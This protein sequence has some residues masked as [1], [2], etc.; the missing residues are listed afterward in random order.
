MK[1]LLSGQTR[2][3]RLSIAPLAVLLLA[4]LCTSAWAGF[5]ETLPKGAFML[6]E[7]FVHS[8]LDKTWDNDGNA[9]PLIEDIKRYEPGGG[10][11]GVLIPKPNAKFYILINKLQY[12][13]LDDLS[14]GLGVPVVLG[15]TID[16]NLQWE[17][18][19]YQ[20]QI[21]RTYSE[22]DFWR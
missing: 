2:F 18:G 12:G 17:S 20:R 21:G 3:A 15:T 5:T 8:W 6:D 16:P 19:D 11:Q 9:M 13:I 1:Q 10:K 22:D 7:G 4:L 14:V